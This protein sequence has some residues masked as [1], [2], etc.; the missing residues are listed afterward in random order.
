[1][2]S[3]PERVTTWRGWIDRGSGATHQ[4]TSARLSASA[5]PRNRLFPKTRSWF[6]LDAPLELLSPLSV[7]R[8]LF[9]VATVAWPL[10]ALT[11]SGI[12]IT[13]MV[14]ISVATA[15]I[16]VVLLLVRK[17]DFRASRVLAG[18]WTVAVGALVWCGQGSGA[19][20]AYALFFVPM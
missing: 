14:V 3:G 5:R 11:H 19:S 15:M 8:V 16:W 4:V 20:V 12:R 7:L 1:M 17:V 2:G 18:W 10:I 13:G 6:A 9:A